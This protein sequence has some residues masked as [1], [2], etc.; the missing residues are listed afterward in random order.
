MKPKNK[1][2]R[3]QQ[4]K[5]WQ[6]SGSWRDSVFPGRQL[7]NH[8]LPASRPVV[9]IR[10]PDRTMLAEN[11][12]YKGRAVWRFE[13]GC[14]SCAMADECLS[15]LLKKSVAAAQLELTRRGFSWEWVK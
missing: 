4:F 14:W 10:H 13:V 12:F 5:S 8:L 9:V 6:K 11:E 7:T 3:N 15:F 2:S 1:Q